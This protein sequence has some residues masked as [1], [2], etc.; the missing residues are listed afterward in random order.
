MKTRTAVLTL[1]ICLAASALCFAA[2]NPNMGT[3]KLNE[4]K[5]KIA[6]GAGKNT[7]VTYEAAGD[8][9]KVT[10]NGVDGSG[11]AVTSVWTG[12]FD[13]KDYPVT[14]DS[15]T[16]AR[17]VKASDKDYH[18]EITNKKGGKVVGTGVVHVAKDG[19]SRT[20]ESKGMDAQGK[21]MKSTY[22][23]DKQ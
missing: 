21:E 14:G 4:A 9:I 8:N 7:T 2:D 6:P 17:S 13:G 12:K 18:L 5:S 23:Y 11:K 16:D 22:F 10:T 1:V 15:R 19:K 20:L 3:W